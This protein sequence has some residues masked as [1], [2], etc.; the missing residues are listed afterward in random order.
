MNSYDL[1]K[2]RFDF[3]FENPD[4]CKATHSELFM[5]ICYLWNSFAQKDKFWLPTIYTM[6][7]IGIKSKKTYY[8]IFNDLVKRW[9]IK[10]IQK[11]ENQNTSTIISIVKQT[12]RSRSKLDD[13]NR[14]GKK[15]TSTYPST[16]TSTVPIDKYIILYTNI[17]NI[18]NIFIKLL[19]EE[20]C[21]NK[22]YYLYIL[23]DMIELW[24]EIQETKEDIENNLK[25]IDE[26][27]KRFEIPTVEMQNKVFQWK[28][29]HTNK[30]T[31][32]TNYKN[33]IY[34]FLTDK[35]KQKK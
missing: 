29:W 23:I 22:K 27:C 2:M 3:R 34:T 10:M 9:F 15:Y 25:W 24:Y 17:D 21:K 32:I 14:L 31:Q 28:T 4:K 6:E 16:D 30:K 19:W 7:M 20:F 18:K 8:S 13:T 33:S 1:H 35:W 12:K 26:T 11:S 5:Y